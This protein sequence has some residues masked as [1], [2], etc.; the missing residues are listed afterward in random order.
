MA[1]LSSPK[2]LKNINYYKY[3]FIILDNPN[4]TFSVEHRFEP[5]G[6]GFTI[7]PPGGCMGLIQNFSVIPDPPAHATMGRRQ[8]RVR[9]ETLPSTGESTANLASSFRVSHNRPGRG[10]TRPDRRARAAKHLAEHQFQLQ[11]RLHLL[12]CRQRQ[13]WWGTVGADDV[14]DRPGGDRPAAR[15]CSAGE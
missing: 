7:R 9:S 5:C 12:L 8:R 14:A 6:L 11:P 4:S 10:S 15:G 13:L 2:Y 1:N 3:T